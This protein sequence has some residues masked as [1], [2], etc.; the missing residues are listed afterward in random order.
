V[1]RLLIITTAWTGCQWGEV[2]IVIDPQ[3]GSLHESRGKRWI[4]PPKTAS[5]ARTI[6][7]PPFLVTMLRDH[8][9]SHPYEYVFTTSS[10]AWLAKIIGKQ[11][12]HPTSTIRSVGRPVH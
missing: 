9:V 6:I 4:G 1:A 2:T 7:L 10:G 5:S 3:C 12:I 11:A 8:L